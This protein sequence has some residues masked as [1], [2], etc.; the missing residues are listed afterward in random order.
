MLSTL[1]L[2]NI[3]VYV[4]IS[5]C[6]ISTDNYQSQRWENILSVLYNDREGVGWNE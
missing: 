1:Q 4:K 3:P 5:A 2:D 6:L